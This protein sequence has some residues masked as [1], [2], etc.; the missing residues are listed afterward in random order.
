ML[1][2][3]FKTGETLKR[4]REDH[5]GVVSFEYIIVATCIVIVVIAVYNSTGTNSISA[6]L[7]SG[8]GKIVTA[9][10]NLP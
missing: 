2:Y 9:M 10:S 1:K 7:T 4:L 8:F 6:A 5:D 3:Y